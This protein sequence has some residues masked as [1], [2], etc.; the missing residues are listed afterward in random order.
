[1]LDKDSANHSSSSAL[2]Q[3]YRMDTTIVTHGL[4]MRDTW[5]TQQTCPAM[6]TPSTSK[7]AMVRVSARLAAASSAPLRGAEVGLVA[8]EADVDAD[9]PDAEAAVLDA[10]LEPPLSALLR[11]ASI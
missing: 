11:F 6:D 3:F 10:G 9:G 7:P 4:L 5:V 8:W 1:M 2:L